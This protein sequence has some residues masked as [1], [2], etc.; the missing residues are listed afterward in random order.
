VRAP[1]PL[2]PLLTP[3]PTPNPH[4]PQMAAMLTILAGYMCVGS[5]G[6]IGGV[7]VRA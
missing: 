6:Y 1:P 7:C 2:T 3:L 5:A 4:T